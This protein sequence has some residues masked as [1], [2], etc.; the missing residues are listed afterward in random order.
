MKSLGA[1]ILGDERYGTGASSS[2]GSRGGSID[3]MYLHAAAIRVPLP[4]GGGWLQVVDA[5]S[6]G[7]LFQHPAVQAACQQLLPQAL[8]N[9]LG[10][11]FGQHKLLRSTTLE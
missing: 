11:W 10:M 2:S 7:S 1:A 9:E 5:P 3:R 4:D 8:E 6:E